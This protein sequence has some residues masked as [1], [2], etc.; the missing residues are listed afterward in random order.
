VCAIRS[1]VEAAV[2]FHLRDECSDEFRAFVGL[3]Y[4]EATSFV[5]LHWAQNRGS[6]TSAPCLY[7]EAQTETCELMVQNQQWITF[8]L[9]LLR[10]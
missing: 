2:A 6:V 5:C 8:V 4:D 10:V 9:I 3:N 7:L 1:V